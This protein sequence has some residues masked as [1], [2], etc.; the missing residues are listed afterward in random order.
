MT[1]K[2]RPDSV[3]NEL[4]DEQWQTL[5]SWLFE[6]NITYREASEDGLKKNGA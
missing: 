2:F 4:T 6:E 5:E 1:R 3:W